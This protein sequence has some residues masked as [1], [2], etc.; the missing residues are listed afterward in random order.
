MRLLVIDPALA[1]VFVLVLVLVI[2]LVFVFVF[3]F[4]SVFV[5]VCL[6]APPLVLALLHSGA[7]KCNR[8]QHPGLSRGVPPWRFASGPAPAP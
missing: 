2:V 5:N 1:V 6:C 4:V 3:V 7:R 8:C